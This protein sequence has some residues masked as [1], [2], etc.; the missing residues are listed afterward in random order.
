M[1]TKVNP[2][3]GKSQKPPSPPKPTKEE[4]RL[5]DNYFDLHGWQFDDIIKPNC[6]HI[7]RYYIGHSGD[8]ARF[9]HLYGLKGQI[10]D[11]KEQIIVTKFLRF[12][13]R[14]YQVKHLSNM[15]PLHAALIKE[16]EYDEWE[17]RKLGA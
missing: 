11:T 17:I 10:P 2:K 3:T 5:L 13:S 7:Q 14:V 9:A 6:I 12:E 8:E 15:E 1:K 16:F 4:F